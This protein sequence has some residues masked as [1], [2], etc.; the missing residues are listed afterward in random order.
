MTTTTVSLTT[1]WAVGLAAVGAALGAGLGAALDPLA[2]WAEGN[3]LPLPWVLH[4]LTRTPRW[5]EVVVPALVGAAGG[6]WVWA[7]WR[8]DVLQ[9]TVEPDGLIVRQ[10]GQARYAARA[11]VAT[12]HADGDDLVVLDAHGGQVVRAEADV[13]LRRAA[14][15]LRAADYPWSD[16]GDPHAD[17][18]RTWVPGRPGLPEDADDLLR[19]RR[20]ALQA[21]EHATLQDLADAL[22]R[23]GVAVRDRAGEQ[24]VR[25]PPAR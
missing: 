19:R 16:D 23:A 25:T 9:L 8:K 3:S 4:L 11:D 2:A 14:A 22:A 18:W 12:V 13:V 17:D 1:G 6:L 7:E 15:A 20:T 10:R 21:K 24:Q 5:A